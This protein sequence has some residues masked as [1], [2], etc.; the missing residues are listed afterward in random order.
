VD[1][2]SRGDDVVVWG[3]E[4]GLQNCSLGGDAR[5]GICLVVDGSSS[6]W[7]TDDGR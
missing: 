3:V 7:L 2:R 4:R 6:E 1:E 5:V